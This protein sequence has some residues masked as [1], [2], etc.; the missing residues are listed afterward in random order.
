MNR[1]PLPGCDPFRIL[2]RRHVPARRRGLNHARK[3]YGNPESTRV[4]DTRVH[5]GV[6]DR[7]YALL[8]SQLPLKSAF[9]AESPMLFGIPNP[10][11]GPFA[12]NG[13]F[14]AMGA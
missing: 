12:A 8:A 6:H 4:A 2:L 3:T 11:S 5:H 13:K 9:A 1:L 14:A 7:A 10:M